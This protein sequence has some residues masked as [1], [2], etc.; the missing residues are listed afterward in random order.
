MTISP[1]RTTPVTTDRMPASILFLVTNEAAERFSYYGMRAILVVFMTEYL[2]N[3]DGAPDLMGEAEA[4]SYFHLFAS[5][6]YFFPIVGALIADVF[7]GKFRTIVVLS[8]VYC[9][10]HLALAV[11]HTR[12][13][14]AIGLTLIA[15]GSGGIKPCVSANLGDQFGSA[16]GHLLSKAF[17]WFYFAINLGAGISTLL[18]PWLLHHVG[19]HVA[20]GVPGLL[21]LLATWVFW[22]GRWQYVHIP[23]KGISFFREL[24]APESLRA[25]RRLTPIFIFSAFFWSLYDQTGSAWVFQ[26]KHMDRH[27]MGIEWLPSQIQVVNP[28][29]IMVLI[30]IFSYG[31]Y[32][33]LSK[34]YPLTP[35]RKIGIGFFVTVLAFL[36]SAQIEIQI[37]EGLRPNIVWQLLAFVV[38]TA[39]EVMVSI[40]CLEFSYTQA[41]RALKSVV[42]ALF[43]LSVSL[44]NAFT[45]LVNVFIQK[46]DGSL[47]LEGAAYYWFFA[48]V[49]LAGSVLFIWVAQ[50][51]RGKTYLQGEET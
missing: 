50:R 20:F 38:I 15:I 9:L 7:W 5:A 11:D 21:M 40:T 8:M 44:G 2:L 39:A 32:P 23:P 45:S 25:I 41:P 16:N 13:G 29:L 30:P 26:A 4:R 17:Y 33:F 28:F 36:I 24:M 19:P 14:L 27:W 6:V 51:Y 48:G 42:M 46:D 34:V 37:A 31:I 3:G 47:V 1:Y 22:I 35:L 18:T 10:G 43:L 49:M 12:M